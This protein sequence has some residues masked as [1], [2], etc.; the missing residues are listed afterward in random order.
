MALRKLL[1]VVLLTLT[2]LASCESTP[3]PQPPT[4]YHL[5][6][7]KIGFETSGPRV[8]AV[9]GQP[10]AVSVGGITLRISPIEDPPTPSP[11][12]AGTATIAG[13][14]SFTIEVDG[15]LENLFYFEAIELQRD[16]YFGVVRG[17]EPGGPGGGADPGP[18]TDEDGSPDAIDCAPDDPDVGGQRC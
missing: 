13:D 15:R 14:G 3:L 2:S 1:S 4:D 10:G 6:P 9:I 8:V 11:V 7:Q 5:D 18:D 12:A 17:I 16:V